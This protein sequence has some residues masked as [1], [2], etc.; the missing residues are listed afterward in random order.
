MAKSKPKAATPVNPLVGRTLAFVGKFGY[1]DSDRASYTI[2]AKAIGA[3]VVDAAKTVPDVLVVGEGRGGKPPGDVAKIQKKSPGVDVYDVDAFV[4]FLIPTPD[5]LLAVIHQGRKEDDHRYWQELE[6]LCR[7]ARTEID[8]QGTDLRKADLYGFGL[9]PV[10]LSRSDLRG[11][12]CEYTHFG[13]L[14]DVKL[15]ECVGKNVYLRNLRRCSFR[16][17]NLAEAWMFWGWDGSA[18]TV[19]DCD[20]TGALMQG[21]RVEKGK[22]TDCRFGG[23]TLCDAEFEHSTFTRADFTKADLSRVHASGTIFR[24]CRFE[25]A[26]LNRADLRGADLRGADLRGAN[27]REAV[28]NDADLTNADVTGAD[29]EN[30][31]LTGAKLQGVN[32]AEA[33]NYT[34]P[35]VR[36]AGPKLLEFAQAAAGAK[37]FETYAEV[38]LGP[39]EFAKLELHLGGNRVGA[40][41]RYVR[42]GNDTFDRLPATSL[43]DG[44]LNLSDRWPKATLRLDSVQAKGS[45]TLRGQKLLDL[46]IAAWAET[47]G[48]PVLSADELKAGRAEQQAA[49]VR[50]R[51]ELMTRIRKEGVTIWNDLDYHI[52]DRYE[53]RGVDLSGANLDEGTFWGRDLRGANF[54]GASLR[55]TEIWNCQLQSANFTGATLHQ[56]EMGSSVL[57]GALFA[58]ADLTECDLKQAKL[59][60]VDFS[61]ANLTGTQ[62]DEAQFDE[63]TVFPAGFAPPAKMLWKGT[64]MRPDVV[65]APAAQAGSLDFETFLTQLAE[66]VE[67]ARMQKAGSMLKA[68]R[69]ELFADV[70]DAS[71][72]GIVKSQSSSDLVYSCRLTSDGGFGC[73]TQNLKPCGGLRGALCK[74][75]L[76][77]IVGLAKAGKLDAA[78]VDHWINLSRGQKPAIDVETMSATFLRYKGAEA[79]EIDWRPTETIP[80]DFFAM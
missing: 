12:N 72:V 27:L 34:P 44:M 70:Q 54:A 71:I 47:F 19:E 5:Q 3:Q 76:V 30:A 21:A 7:K 50:E 37:S 77:L 29:L 43:E 1:G 26:N 45:K 75:L 49:A 78:T 15:D 41:S 2:L 63:T 20:F 51:D 57:A 39:N 13:H 18:D 65:V 67:A 32:V 31:V 40:V 68:E 38:D 52:R 62:L 60:G 58:G 61:Q 11:A 69:F 80:E 23:A 48:V 74:H 66:K 17:A 24:E 42:E 10:Q 46:A 64:G 53:L 9:E 28:L 79:G 14:E 16:K 55:K 56:C 6:G 4:Q 22:L 73:C 36:T 25:K 33:K 35:K 8:L 59:Q